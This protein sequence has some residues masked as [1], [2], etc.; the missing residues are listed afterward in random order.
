ML[1]NKPRFCDND[2]PTRI[3]LAEL[4][5]ILRLCQDVC[6]FPVLMIQVSMLC[7]V[8]KERK[9]KLFSPSVSSHKGPVPSNADS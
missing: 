7:V 3:G 8:R 4:L 9:E 1:R 5:E 2:M 6:Y